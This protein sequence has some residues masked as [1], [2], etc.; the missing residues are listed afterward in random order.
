M[1]P[2]ASND[3]ACRFCGAPLRH[4]FVD[5]GM[6]PLCESYLAPDQLNRDGG[7]LSAPRVRV[8]AVLPGAA[9]GVRAAR[10]DL[11]AS[12]RISR[13]TRRPGW[14]TRGNTPNR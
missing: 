1:S 4:T 9:A 14:S 2:D 12:T 8:R 11:H 6:S 13:R 3:P 5:L 7:V 10:S